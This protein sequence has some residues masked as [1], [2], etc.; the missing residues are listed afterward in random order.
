MRQ[1]L[2]TNLFTKSGENHSGYARFP[3]ACVGG[4]FRVS[5]AQHE[6]GQLGPLI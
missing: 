6:L 1:P 5:G 3:L 2:L 4:V